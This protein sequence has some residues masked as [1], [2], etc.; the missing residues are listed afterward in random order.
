[1]SIFVAT[2]YKNKKLSVEIKGLGGTIR[3]Q[4]FKTVIVRESSLTSRLQIFCGRFWSRIR[5]S[6]GQSSASLRIIAFN[7]GLGPFLK[8]RHEL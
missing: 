2:S 8:R 4:L 6:P 3:Y 5:E 7:T 1:M